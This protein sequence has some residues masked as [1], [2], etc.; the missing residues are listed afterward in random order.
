MKTI[1]I[2]CWKCG[3]EIIKPKNEYDRQRRRGREYFYC[4]I[5]C[6][7]SDNLTIHHN[8]VSKCLWCKKE[9]ETTTHKHARKCCSNFCRNRY[10]QSFVNKEKISLSVKEA[11]RR[12]D[13][14]EVDFKNQYGGR[15][16]DPRIYN[17][18][19]VIC[20]KQ[21]QRIT[22]KLLSPIKT[23]SDICYRDL[24]RKKA[25]DNPNCGGETG[26]RHYK[27][28]EI[29][30]DSKW[31]M[32]M[33]K[34]MD[35]WGIKWDR[36]RKRHMFWW[37]DDNGSKRRYYPDFYLPELNVYLDPKNKYKMKN[38]KIKME[39]VIKENGIVLFWGLLENI[40]KEIDI[41]RKM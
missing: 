29:W 8:V 22:K 36:S 19:C 5:S 39:R 12:G 11:W 7:T 13:F 31:E 38:D 37:T 16:L 18:T 35:E 21:F 17:F 34:W 27:Y 14:D 1:L 9:F 26:Y 23:C 4:S 32:E 41:L 3:K 6:S 20:G 25:I 24:L 10:A 28:K 15:I 40:K 33:A 30:M 2:N